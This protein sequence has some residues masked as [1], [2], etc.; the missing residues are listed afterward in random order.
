MNISKKRLLAV[1]SFVQLAV[2]PSYCQ[3]T[4]VYDSL[5]TAATAGTSRASSENP[6]YGDTLTLSAGGTLANFGLTLYN[7]SSSAGSITNGTTTVKFYDNTIPYT[8][9]TINVQTLLGTAVVNWAYVGGD[10][11]DP[12]VFDT[13]V[14]DLS[15][16]GIVLPQNVLVTQQFTQTSGN[17]TRWGVALL[18]DPVVGSSPNTVFISSSALSPGLY[19]ISGGNPGQVG[20]QIDIGPGGG[21]NHRPVANS[22]NLSVNANT[23][24]P[25]T[26]T[27]TDADNDPLTYSIATSP[28]NGNLTGTPPN[29]T[30]TPNFGYSGPDSFTF[31]AN[32]G[33]TNSAPATISITV[34]PPL[35]GLIIN[36]T[37]DTTITSDP[38]AAA[39]MNTISN[40]ILVYET[41][42]S[43]NVTVN[44]KFAEMGS[45]LGMS[46]TFFSPISY[47]TFFNA[48]VADSKTTNDVTALAHIPLNGGID[49]V[50]NTSSIRVTTANQRALGLSASISL[51]GTIFLNMSIINI[52]RP[53][54]DLSKFDL[55]AVV[56]HEID[57]VLGTSSALSS[58]GAEAN[59]R[60]ADLFRYTSGGL[61]TYTTVSAPTFDD[62]WFSI[63]GGITRPVRF[64]QS[65][66]A[67][68]GDWWSTGAHTA[69][70]QDAFGTAGA[71]PNLGV[72][73][74]FLDVIG[75]DLVIPAPVPTIQSVG[76]TGNTINF[77]WASAVGHGY[78]VQYKTN[79][80]QVGW[81]NL[82]SPITAI[83]TT[84]S[85]SDTIGPDPR[86][87][88]RIALLTSSPAPP[89]VAQ[90]NGA[91]T[92][93]YSLVT[94]YFLPSQA[95]EI[96]GQ[97][98]KS[99]PALQIERA[100]PFK[101]TA[102]VEV[103][104][105]N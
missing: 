35:A 13:Q 44:I 43:D 53:P 92:G 9:G 88:Y 31:T 10:S 41:K 34:N 101:G 73:L 89:T 14:V 20:Y 81:L 83:S 19:T 52:T 80:T 4:T 78:Q 11:L 69:R 48:L 57:E 104:G 30:Y 74:T 6:I 21:G 22:Q 38:N 71:T 7:S 29:V 33:Q 12:G 60:P 84:T 95:M 54:A 85:S 50:D 2:L 86:R 67:D 49:P 28:A 51:D 36:P 77:S 47:T 15:G 25:I 39:I 40:A 18:S 1:V 55:M 45:G 75:W 97:S 58:S 17:S 8:S 100:R 70:V 42:F 63:D 37:W 79:L 103:R 90:V 46:S 68:Y 98:A 59:S 66:G 96:K 23:S 24:L 76:R 64:N 5:S 94:N 32:D 102:R 91:P 82:N 61:R 87:F 56:S 26:L 62:A 105:Q 3:I 93:P 27:A 99:L 65:A 16:L 72:E